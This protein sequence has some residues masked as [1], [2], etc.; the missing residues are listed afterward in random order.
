MVRCPRVCSTAAGTQKNQPSGGS[1]ILFS[2]SSSV[3]ALFAASWMRTNR[4]K[5]WHASVQFCRLNGEQVFS[6]LPM[7]K[8][9]YSHLCS[10]AGPI[11]ASRS[12]SAPTQEAG[13]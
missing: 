3:V 10:S 12:F 4:V 2:G 7:T 8:A 6:E 9:K 5:V 11:N 1:E 13:K